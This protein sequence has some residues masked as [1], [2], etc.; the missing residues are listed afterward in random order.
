[1][2]LAILFLP[3]AILAQDAPKPTDPPVISAE[4]QRAFEHAIN[5]E[6]ESKALHDADV[7]ARDKA[8]AEVVKA[9]GD[10]Y[11]PWRADRNAPLTCVA[12]PEQK[13]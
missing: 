8:L 7:A 9:C 11:T 3:L 10:N 4:V 5:L 12:K 2:K 13:K 1:M 6:A